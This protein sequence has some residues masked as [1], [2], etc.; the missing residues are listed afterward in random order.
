MN[1]LL[2]IAIGFLPSLL[3]LWL[4][5]KSQARTRSRFRRAASTIYPV[6][7]VQQNRIS[8]DNYCTE[9][10][11]LRG[12]R[13]YLEGVGYLVGDISCRFNARSGY[14]RCAVNPSGPCEGCRL[15]QAKETVS[16]EKSSSDY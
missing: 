15:Y 11:T 9:R 6:G 16:V 1:I 13:Y 12:D 4:M 8:D 5:R 14:L 3:S 7:R 2:V 10:S